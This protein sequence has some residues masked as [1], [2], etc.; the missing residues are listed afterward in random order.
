MARYFN[1]LD[2]PN[3][4]EIPLVVSLPDRMKVKL[5]SFLSEDFMIK[6]SKVFEIIKEVEV[7]LCIIN[8]SSLSL[9]ISNLENYYKYPDR[10][11]QDSV[12]LFVPLQRLRCYKAFLYGIDSIF[13]RNDLEKKYFQ[14]FYIPDTLEKRTP[15]ELI[16]FKK[17]L[18]NETII[19]NNQELYEYIHF[20]YC[21]LNEIIWLC[22]EYEEIWKEKEHILECA[23]DS[24]KPVLY[25]AKEI[26]NDQIIGYYPL[27]SIV[28]K[29]NPSY[30]YACPRKYPKN[31]KMDNDWYITPYGDLFNNGGHY[32]LG[33]TGDAKSLFENGLYYHGNLQGFNDW[34][35]IVKKRYVDNKCQGHT[36]Y[37]DYVRRYRVF[38]D[39]GS[40]SGFAHL[41]IPYEYIADKNI[42]KKI[43]VFDP[44]MEHTTERIYTKSVYR[45][46]LG[47]YSTEMAYYSFYEELGNYTKK[48]LEELKKISKLIKNNKEEAIRLIGFHRIEDN[49]SKTITTSRFLEIENLNEYLEKGWNICYVPPIII[50]REEGTLIDQSQEMSLIQN[51]YIENYIEEYERSRGLTHG[52]I[53]IKSSIN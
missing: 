44:I 13:T 3:D 51:R 14:E 29:N 48:P 34:L 18:D 39:C 16:Q 19:T 26:V 49:T 12:S 45:A 41:F 50:S 11:E 28:F 10:L 30:A 27:L 36:D 53:Y 33:S 40:D 24:L 22:P 1:E 20:Y 35:I 42:D 2:R 4:V 21:V 15:E 37:I 46:V 32:N 6:Y 9:R 7:L 52:R 25:F 17:I 43:E 8:T 38:G 31:I 47:T 23:I 5:E